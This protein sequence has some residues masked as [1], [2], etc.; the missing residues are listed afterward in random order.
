MKWN[1]WPGVK[2]PTA[3]HTATI[4][5]ESSSESQCRGFQI[6]GGCIYI[7]SYI[8]TYHIYIYII[9]IYMIYIYIYIMY[10][11]TLYIHHIHIISYHIISY[12]YTSYPLYK[13]SLASCPNQQKHLISTS[14]TFFQVLFQ[15]ITLAQAKQ[16]LS[17]SLLC[18]TSGFPPQGRWKNTLLPPKKP[19]ETWKSTRK[20]QQNRPNSQLALSFV[21]SNTFQV[22]TA[23]AE[24]KRPCILWRTFKN[25]SSL[26]KNEEPGFPAFFVG[27]G[28]QIIIFSFAKRTLG[29]AN[30]RSHPIP[31]IPVSLLTWSSLSQ[32]TPK[33]IKVWT[34]NFPAKSI[35]PK[36]VS[37]LA[38]GQVIWKKSHRFPPAFPAIQSRPRP[39]PPHRTRRDSWEGDRR[40][41]L[42][43][44]GNWVYPRCTPN[45][46]PMVVIVF[47]DGI[48]GDYKQVCTWKDGGPKRKGSSANHWFSRANC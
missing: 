12:I 1:R 13:Y 6:T 23:T 42:D 4:M 28:P 9:Y 14:N 39:H 8:Y 11:C 45:S 18:P 26:S 43:S 48:L 33:K 10:I 47:S 34:L 22:N 46:V 29:K 35:N 36:K 20:I 41:G 37:S 44:R 30:L 2:I 21:L 3:D 16:L 38:I 5:K 32:W 40:H 19:V 17:E 7:C 15:L 25:S 24:E 27:G 31:F